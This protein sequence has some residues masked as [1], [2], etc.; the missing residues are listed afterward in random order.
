MIEQHGLA[1]Q[2]GEQILRMLDRRSLSAEYIERKLPLAAN[3]LRAL[4]RKKFVM[5]EQV[6]AERDPLRASSE[7]L[8][9]ELVGGGA[10]G[11]PP[12]AER[13]LLAFLELHP[14]THNLKDLEAMVKD[15]SPAARSLARKKLLL[16][17]TEPPAIHSAPI[18]APSS[19]WRWMFSR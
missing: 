2:R 17:R 13:E 5:V 10:A 16:L 15:A 19:N 4:E 11:K 14:G 18:R 9:V 8:R 7:R 1:R 12:K 6:E 3:A